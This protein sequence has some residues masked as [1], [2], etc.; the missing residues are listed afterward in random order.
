MADLETLISPEVLEPFSGLVIA[1]SGRDIGNM[2]TRFGNATDT[3]R[4]RAILRGAVPVNHT[5]VIWAQNGTDFADLTE[6]G[7]AQTRQTGF[8]DES[9]IVG[10]GLVTSQKN[11][12]LM[13]NGGDCLPLVVYQPEQRLL[14]LIHMG[15]MGTMGS[16]HHKVLGHMREKHQLDIR[17]AFAYL[18]PSV[19]STSYVKM[20]LFDQQIQDSMWQD[21]ITPNGVGYHVDIP[22]FVIDGLLQ[23][24]LLRSRIEVSPIDTAASPDRFSHVRHTLYSETPG[25]NGFIATMV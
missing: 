12:G 3:G 10:D 19:H 17:G 8:P 24:G 2:D 13:L 25:R 7:V 18:G 21:H 11:T 16:L 9:A 4:A 1:Q 20:D 14:A 5:F 15:I 22:G 23:Q 6:Y